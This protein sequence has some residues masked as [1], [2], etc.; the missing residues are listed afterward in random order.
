MGKASAR[1]Y[2]A[3]C[4]GRA[5]SCKA[6]TAESEHDDDRVNHP[7]RACV[8]AVT[9]HDHKREHGAYRDCDH[10]IFHIHCARHGAAGVEA[11][12]SLRGRHGLP[13][14]QAV[15]ANGSCS[16]REP[17]RG[18]DLAS[19]SACAEQEN[20][21]MPDDEEIDSGSGLENVSQTS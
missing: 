21:I 4:L 20:G 1:A 5:L 16:C 10:R 7:S 15:R 19:A 3:D 2:V 17:A 14:A 9:Y 13:D 8:P 6:A 18:S 11:N 12:E